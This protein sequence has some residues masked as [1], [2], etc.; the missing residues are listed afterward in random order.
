M[1]KLKILLICDR[2]DE[3]SIIKKLFETPPLVDKFDL[4]EDINGEHSYFPYTLKR[5][6][7]IEP[8]QQKERVKSAIISR[9]EDFDILAIGM[10]MPSLLDVLEVID[11]LKPILTNKAIIFILRSETINRGDL[12]KNKK[13]DKYKYVIIDRPYTTHLNENVVGCRVDLYKSCKKKGIKPHKCKKID[14]FREFF[15]QLHTCISMANNAN[16]GWVG[17]DLDGTLAELTVWGGADCIGKPIPNMVEKVKKLLSQGV[18]VKILTARV[19]SN[20]SDKDIAQKA[21]EKWTEANIGVKLPVTSE[22]DYLM[23]HCYDDRCT[24]V[25]MNTGVCVMDVLIE[26]YK[27]MCSIPLSQ[28]Q[29]WGLDEV[30]IT[31]MR[32][33]SK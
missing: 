13:W 19:A 28:I 10:F 1:S 8:K 24:Q 32:A 11:E 6:D 33:L 26:T 12:L 21:I 23:I 22:K 25:V 7:I 29:E 20:S 31:M 18:P 17:F 2:L 14:C 3:V 16:K 4:L 30:F 9:I 5:G 15:V 27:K